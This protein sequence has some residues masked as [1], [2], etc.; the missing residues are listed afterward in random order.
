MLKKDFSHENWVVSYETG[1]KD[2]QVLDIEAMTAYIISLPIQVPSLIGV[3]VS[4]LIIV[5]LKGKITDVALLASDQWIVSTE[6][7]KEKVRY[8]VS[9]TNTGD[10]STMHVSDRVRV[11]FCILNN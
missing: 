9:R 1:S 7:E 2:I 4:Q 10:V 5:R 3:F 8:L 11:S 6:S